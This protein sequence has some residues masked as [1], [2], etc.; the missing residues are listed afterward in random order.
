MQPNIIRSY[1]LLTT[2]HEFWKAVLETYSHIGN[3][4][5]VYELVKEEHD[6]NKARDPWLIIIQK[7]ELFA[8]KLIL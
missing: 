5:Q 4:V 7:S 6:T 1:V 3:E 8:K 2:A